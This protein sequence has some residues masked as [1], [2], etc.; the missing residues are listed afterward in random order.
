MSL[1]RNTNTVTWKLTY[2]F[3]AAA[4]NTPAIPGL[5]KTHT[6]EQGSTHGQY[7]PE[8]DRIGRRRPL[9]VGLQ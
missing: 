4:I 8:E 2:K 5:M 3:S 9:G 6:E 1:D 7:N